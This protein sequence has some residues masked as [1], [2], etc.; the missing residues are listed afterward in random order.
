MRI[1]RV[2]HGLCEVFDSLA[3]RFSRF[4]PWEGVVDCWI[5]G[6]EA[7]CSARHPARNILAQAL[8][9]PS[10]AL[11]AVTK[12]RF[13]HTYLHKPSQLHL[14]FRGALVIGHLL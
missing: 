2:E 3:L 12:R 8:R 10:R 4:G 11:T 7:L 5:W 14:A 9:A 1:A 13:R 6:G